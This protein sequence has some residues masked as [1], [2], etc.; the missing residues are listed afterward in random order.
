MGCIFQPEAEGFVELPSL[1]H[2]A[3]VVLKSQTAAAASDDLA[4][5]REAG[6]AA[7]L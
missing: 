5:G 3:V 4:V 1:Q 6:K 2:V 7:Q